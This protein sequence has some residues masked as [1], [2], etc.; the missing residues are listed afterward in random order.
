MVFSIKFY[1]STCKFCQSSYKYCQ[2]RNKPSNISQSFFNFAKA[3]KF[4]PNLVTLWVSSFPLFSSFSIIGE[5]MS[6][7]SFQRRFKKTKLK[8][9]NLFKHFN[10]S[11]PKGFLLLHLTLL[12]IIRSWPNRLRCTMHVPKTYNWH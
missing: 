7:E 3:V 6:K 11:L 1:Q 2:V 9:S 12:L 10:I 8:T 5:K 4:L